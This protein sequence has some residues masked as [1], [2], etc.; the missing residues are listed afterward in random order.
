M[1]EQINSMLLAEHILLL[2]I[3]I[4]IAYVLFF[5]I[6]IEKS[7]KFKNVRMAIYKVGLIS[8]LSWTVFYS[9]VQICFISIFFVDIDVWWYEGLSVAD[10][11]ITSLFLLSYIITKEATDG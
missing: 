11:L 1:T 2:A 8:I 6:K 9:I 7:P 10:Q 5:Q 4:A 3:K